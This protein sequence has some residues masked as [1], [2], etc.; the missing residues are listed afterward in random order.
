MTDSS[1]IARHLIDSTLQE[2]D[3]VNRNDPNVDTQTQQPRALRQ[4]RLA[5]IWLTRLDDAPSPELEAAVRAHH[6]RRWE[7][8]RSDYPEGRAGYLKWRRDN[9]VHQASSLAAIMKDLGWPPP[10][11]ERTTELLNRT[12]LRTDPETQH[13][14]DVACLV[15]LETELQ[16]MIARLERGHMARVAQK[17]AD[18]MSPE[19][20][21]LIDTIALTETARQVLA[22]ASQG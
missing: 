2:V 7:V 14:E 12:R 11:V 6:L 22:E 1:A 20:V 4:G 21:A 5:S 15:F 19:A 13:L 8:L 18:K 10:S 9:K 17:T 16:A 3:E